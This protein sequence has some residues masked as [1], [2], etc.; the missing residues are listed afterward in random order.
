MGDGRSRRP[1]AVP[2]HDGPEGDIWTAVSTRDRADYSSC[3]TAAAS[4]CQATG[5][6]SSSFKDHCRPS[7]AWIGTAWIQH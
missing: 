1:A 3:S 7:E 5:R 2:T 6:P 4:S